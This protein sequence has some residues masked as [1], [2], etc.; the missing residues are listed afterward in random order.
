M[1]AIAIALGTCTLASL[2]SA[3]FV[4]FT[5]TPTSSIA[6]RKVAFS[7]WGLI[8][9]LLAASAVVIGSTRASPSPLYPHVLVCIS[10]AITCVWSATVTRARGIAF[11]ALATS[12][13]T[14]WASL[15]AVRDHL[16]LLSTAYG[17]LAGWLSVA[18]TISTLSDDTRILVLASTLVGSG[19]VAIGTP[20]PSVALLWGLVCQQRVDASVWTSIL[21]TLLAGV[22]S[23]FRARS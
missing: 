16:L 17:L 11:L 2:V 5:Q 13:A 20:W 1:R 14:A 15:H 6:P 23:V 9:T 21:V 12:A 10:L 19:C 18:T 4:D 8:Y 22:G 3:S 7:I